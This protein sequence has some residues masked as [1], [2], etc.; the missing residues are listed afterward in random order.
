MTELCRLELD[1]KRTRTQ[2]TKATGKRSRDIDDDLE[3][4]DVL[5]SKEVPGTGASS[6][7]ASSIQFPMFV[8]CPEE[9]WLH[10]HQANPRT[11]YV[12]QNKD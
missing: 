7:E 2:V 12:Y 1:S 9:T 4:H 8:V 3:P 11:S 5:A 10:R 6:T